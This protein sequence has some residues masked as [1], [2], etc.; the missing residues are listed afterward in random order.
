[1][2]ADLRDALLAFGVEE[3]WNYLKEVCSSVGAGELDLS[4][5]YARVSRNRHNAAHNPDCNIASDDIKSHLRSIL[6]VAVASHVTLAHLAACST[7][8]RSF[9]DFITAKAEPPKIRFVD[10]ERV[11]SWV[12][13]KA[14]SSRVIK[15]YVDEEVAVLR[16]NAR[17]GRPIVVVRDESQRPVRIYSD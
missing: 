8:A 14:D 17:S 3:P 9:A 10:R 6:D 12:E 16:A 7:D 4:S 1:M 2:S 15:R 11:N 5:S 13:R